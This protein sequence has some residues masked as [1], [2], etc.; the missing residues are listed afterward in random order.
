MGLVDDLLLAQ[1]EIVIIFLF[2]DDV[3]DHG[4]TGRTTI[5]GNDTLFTKTL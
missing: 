5:I 4:Q 2:E 1:G 3:D